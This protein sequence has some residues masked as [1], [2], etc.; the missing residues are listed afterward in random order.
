LPSFPVGDQ[1]WWPRAIQGAIALASTKKFKPGGFMTLLSICAAIVL[2]F[3]SKSPLTPELFQ[4]VERLCKVAIGGYDE[5]RRRRFEELSDAVI[6]KLTADDCRVLRSVKTEEPSKAWLKTVIRTTDIDLYRKNN[7][8]FNWNQYGEHSR[9]ICNLVVN[10]GYPAEEA[11][12]LLWEYPPHYEISVDEIKRI[13]W[14]I[15]SKGALRFR[16][17]DNVTFESHDVETEMPDI[18]F[19]DESPLQDDI[20]I[21]HTLKHDEMMAIRLFLLR[22]SGK[23]KVLISYFYGLGYAEVPLQEIADMLGSTVT[24][25]QK[26]KDRLIFDFRNW[27]MKQKI[28]LDELICQ[29]LARSAS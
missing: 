20:L 1:H 28:S 13:V 2:P 8:R 15:Q 21:E 6:S 14:E 27:L 26:R 12:R 10:Y 9:M 23:D 3:V 24:A 11:Q 22:L 5:S 4:E 17:D 25:L 19:A 18:T 16:I 29:Q 7:G